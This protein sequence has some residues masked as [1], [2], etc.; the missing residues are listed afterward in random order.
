LNSA[1][2][3]A[4]FDAA[5][6]RM[7]GPRRLGALRLQA[8]ALGFAGKLEDAVGV[9]ERAIS[10]AAEDSEMVL[11][12]TGRREFFAA[13]WPEDPDHARRPS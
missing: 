12:L 2:A 6:E 10:R 11:Q 5:A 13:W 1:A 4:A 7:G 9:Y 3:G 8:Y